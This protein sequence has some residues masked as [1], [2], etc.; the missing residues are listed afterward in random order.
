M[1]SRKKIAVLEEQVQN[2]QAELNNTKQA[3]N[4][5]EQELAEAQ[6]ELHLTIDSLQSSSQ[7]NLELRTKYQPIIDVEKAVL[8]QQ[9]VID[10]ASQTI[11]DLNNK[12]QQALI[13]HHSLEQEISLF[14]DHLEINSFGL[15]KPQFNF[16]TSD[17][18]KAAIEA[19]YEAQKN[20]I[21][22][23]TAIICH[24]EWSVSG[25]KAEGRK[26]TAKYKKLM[27]FAFNGES[28]SLIAKVKWNNAEKSVDR[29]K[30]AFESINKLGETHSIEITH[31]FFQLKLE[32]L[33]LTY[34]FEQ[35]KYEEKEEQRRIR[36]QMREEEKAQREF[37]RAQREAEDEEYRYQKALEKAKAEFNA[38]TQESSAILSE[39]VRLLEQQLQEA[40]E[41][42]ERAMAMAQLTKVGHIYVI[43]NIGSFGED[44]YKMGM[45]RRLDPLDRVRELGDA[46]V[47]FLF[48]VHAIIYSENAPQLE[49][50]LHQHFNDRRLNRINGKKE[51][52]RV[53]L[54]EIEAFVLKHTGTEIQ[55]T[56]V[57]EAKD[58]RETMAMLEK[59]KEKD[60]PVIEEPK[61][62]GTLI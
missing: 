19:N 1:F 32:E 41:K 25:S 50:E 10:E 55:F 54:E 27:L 6:K 35:K 57:A 34:E 39:R 47:P 46:S 7:S 9:A 16:D 62:P 24:T 51:F 17:Q 38:A 30:K 8:E 12:Y 60:S 23:D 5:K 36:E 14:E 29:I 42:K 45:T 59:L 21:K 13:I 56:K 2:L 52:F 33:R 48:D 44:V 18:F 61:F 22:E 20:M 49:Y 58:Y 15:Y 28:D 26:M 31:P 53:S 43:S 37:E 11:A 3:L 4:T 40:H